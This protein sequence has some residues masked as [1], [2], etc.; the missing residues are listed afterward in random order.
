MTRPD[1]WPQSPQFQV[2][3]LIDAG[4]EEPA[5]TGPTDPHLHLHHGHTLCRGFMSHNLQ[6]TTNNT[7][8]HTANNYGENMEQHPIALWATRGS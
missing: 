7:L 1:D 8:Q 2:W 5:G 4:T 6:H 3:S